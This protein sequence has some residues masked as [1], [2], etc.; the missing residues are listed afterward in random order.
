[1]V[2]SKYLKRNYI[3]SSPPKSYQPDQMNNFYTTEMRKKLSEPRSR[4]IYSKRFPSI[5]GVFGA[6]KGSREGDVFLTKGIEKMSLEWSEKC[7][8]HNIAK[9]CGF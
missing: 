8:A 4:V 9:L 6:I 5:E 2:N 7:S 3:H 1:M